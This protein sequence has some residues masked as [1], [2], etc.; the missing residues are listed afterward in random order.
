MNRVAKVLENHGNENSVRIWTLSRNKWVKGCAKSFIKIIF[1]RWKILLVWGYR[2]SVPITPTVIAATKVF[3]S[4]RSQWRMTAGSVYIG[5]FL[6][7][8]VTFN[9][10]SWPACLSLV[11]PKGEPQALS[12]GGSCEWCRNTSRNEAGRGRQAGKHALLTSYKV[13]T[14]TFQRLHGSRF[15]AVTL[16]HLLL[17][18]VKLAM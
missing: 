3:W 15:K 9:K 16:C 14:A 12:I 1:F 11:P 8:V 5:G 18:V 10:G 6:T 7:A 13:K 2:V 17:C 4:F